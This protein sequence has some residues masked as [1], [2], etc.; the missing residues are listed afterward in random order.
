MMLPPNAS[1]YYRF[2]PGSVSRT[3]AD[4]AWWGRLGTPRRAEA[5]KSVSYEARLRVNRK[6]RRP[7]DL[8]LD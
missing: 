8:G 1:T 2:Q 3:G 6:S 7:P 4:S 5:P